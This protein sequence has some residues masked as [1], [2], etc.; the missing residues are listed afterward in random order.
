M[1]SIEEVVAERGRA[2]GDFAAQ[3]EIEQD[4]KE[5]M[6]A[7]TQWYELEAYKRASLEMIAHKISRI[8]NGDSNHADSWTDIEGYARIARTRLTPP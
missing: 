5:I 4:L 1:S 8:L 3:A 2:Y 6:R 7:C